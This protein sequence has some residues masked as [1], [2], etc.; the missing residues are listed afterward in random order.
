MR[1]TP[2]RTRVPLPT[3]PARAPSGTSA[4]AAPVNEDGHPCLFQLCRCWC[5]RAPWA[6]EPWRRSLTTRYQWLLRCAA[7]HA[8]AI[9]M[10]SVVRMQ[11][12]MLHPVDS[13]RLAA[14]STARDGRARRRARAGDRLVTRTRGSESIGVAGPRQT[15]RVA[16]RAA[17]HVLRERVP[18]SRT[19]DVFG[20]ACACG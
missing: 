11:H 3:S 7:T 17:R 8:L 12:T 2:N 13:G 15:A 10:A 20:H 14:R 5:P 9:V 1:F 19:R 4:S 16:S 18:S 6:A